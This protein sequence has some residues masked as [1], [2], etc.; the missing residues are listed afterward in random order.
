MIDPN[1]TIEFVV[2]V[3]VIIAVFAFYFGVLVPAVGIVGIVLYESELPDLSEVI[4]MWKF[5][6]SHP[7]TASMVLAV[8]PFMFLYD[9]LS[10]WR[11]P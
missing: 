9:L 2:S 6:A 3:I 7:I 4:D 8:I 10:A 11:E 5:L 1:F